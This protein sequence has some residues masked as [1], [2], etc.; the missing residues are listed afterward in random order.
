MFGIPKIAAA[1]AALSLFAPG[2][3]SAPASNLTGSADDDLVKRAPNS[4]RSNERNGYIHFDIWSE[5]FYDISGRCAGLWANFQPRFPSCA[6]TSGYCGGIEDTHIL[7]WN[8]NVPL[9]CG[10][11]SVNSAWW[12]ATRNEFGPLFC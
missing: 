11:G 10:G 9:G 7:N 8:F 2:V 5:N 3:A 6:V 4:C 12:E 1:A